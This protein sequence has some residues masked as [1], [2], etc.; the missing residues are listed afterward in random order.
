MVREIRKQKKSVEK[1]KSNNKK[2][3]HK[4]ERIKF[5]FFWGFFLWTET[6]RLRQ[7]K[8][9]FFQRHWKNNGKMFFEDHAWKN[10][11]VAKKLKIKK[12]KGFFQKK[13]YVLHFLSNN[14]TTFFYETRK[15]DWYKKI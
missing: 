12:N 1:K 3:K 15:E 10:K 9:Y 13:K 6:K 7:K 5:F 2:S 14:K 4:F 8:Q 11:S